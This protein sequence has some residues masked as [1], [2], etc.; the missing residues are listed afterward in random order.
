MSELLQSWEAFLL[1]K[2]IAV[3]KIKCTTQEFKNPF[4]KN[5]M[6][7]KF[8]HSIKVPKIYM[9][10]VKVKKTYLN[11]L[12]L[13]GP[14]PASRH[15]LFL[16][17]MKL[18]TLSDQPH[19]CKTEE[20]SF[21]RLKEYNIK[22]LANKKHSTGKHERPNRRKRMKLRLAYKNKKGARDLTQHCIMH[23]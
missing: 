15:N 22:K 13:D 4:T 10:H 6:Y 8:D 9:I 5:C 14:F 23:F 18:W 2:C 3:Q 17:L 21:L 12:L 20:A 16:E 1:M 19:D 7:L 11:S